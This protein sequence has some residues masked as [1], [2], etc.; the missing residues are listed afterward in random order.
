MIWFMRLN[1]TMQVG[2][3]DF[4]DSFQKYTTPFLQRQEMRH[5]GTSEKLLTDYLCVLAKNDLRP[6]L[7]IFKTAHTK[8]TPSPAE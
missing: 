5:P 8:V 3:D 1:N 2:P 7:C 4:A 6:C